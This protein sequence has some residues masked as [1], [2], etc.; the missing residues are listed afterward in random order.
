MVQYLLF[1]V[2]YLGATLCVPNVQRFRGGLIFKAHRLSCNSTL[3]LS[4]IEK[5][6]TPRVLAS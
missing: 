6:Q 4:L 5:K 3:G 2:E 1:T